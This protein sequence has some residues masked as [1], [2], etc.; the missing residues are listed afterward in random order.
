LHLFEGF[1]RGDLD[2]QSPP[3]TTRK[4]ARRDIFLETQSIVSLGT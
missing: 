2:L 1:G 4:L 3:T